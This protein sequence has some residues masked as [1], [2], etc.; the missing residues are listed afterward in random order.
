AVTS[1]WQIGSWMRSGP[2]KATT[3]GS[4][5]PLASRCGSSFP[6]ESANGGGDELNAATRRTTTKAIPTAPTTASRPP[7]LDGPRDGGRLDVRTGRPVGREVTIA[8]HRSAVPAVR[9]TAAAPARTPSAADEGGT[10]AAHARTGQDPDPSLDPARRPP[11]APPLP[12]GR[13]RRRQARPLPVR[14]R[15]ARRPLLRSHRQVLP[16]RARAAR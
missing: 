9:Q 2:W 13:C 15:V 11:A 7:C 4:G 1:H 3:I 12:V 6:T 5:R 8:R 10:M 16:P 14:G